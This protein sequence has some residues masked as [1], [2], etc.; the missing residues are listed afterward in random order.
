MLRR[1]ARFV[2]GSYPPLPSLLFAVAW[3]YGVTGL[4]AAVDPR[5]SHWR[6]D[7]G[8]AVAALTLA[9]DLLLMRAL[10]DIRDL[11][12]DRRFNPGRPLAAGAVRTG[13]L[14]ILYAVGS[15]LLL[16]LNAGAPAA[17]A[18]LAAQLGYGVLVVAVH[19]RLRWPSGDD[20]LL[21]LLV[22]F[23]AQLLLHLYLYAG[24]LH[25]TGLAPD[26]NSLLAI[27]IVVLA[28]VHL[29]LAKKITRAPGPGERTYV[30]VFGLAGTTAVALIAPV[31][32]TALLLPPALRSGGAWAL[33][34]VV[35]LA[36]PAV[37]GWRFFRTA[38][39]RWSAAAPALYLLLTFTGYFLLGLAP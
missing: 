10:D 1:W 19:L 20:L 22:S 26:R 30:D 11:D 15:A 4:F 37:A 13:D 14:I 7:A 9:V 18:V 8:T 32:S 29:E 39:P 27:G 28:S 16:I 17:M 33:V 34:A 6:P 2:A 36:L 24:Y 5:T 25:G 3:A 21:S 38:A 23:P 31:V 35:P 12:Y